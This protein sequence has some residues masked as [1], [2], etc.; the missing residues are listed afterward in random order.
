MPALFA[1]LKDVEPEVSEQPCILG[2]ESLFDK[3][4]R[5]RKLIVDDDGGVKVKIEQEIDHGDEVDSGVCWVTTE[6]ETDKS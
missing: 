6:Q 2:S 1:E 4:K 5:K 3:R